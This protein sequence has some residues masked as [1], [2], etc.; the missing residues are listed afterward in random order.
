MTELLNII[1]IGGGALLLVAIIWEWV[2]TI[3][4]DDGG[5]SI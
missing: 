1:V 4:N 3:R 5:D 2:D